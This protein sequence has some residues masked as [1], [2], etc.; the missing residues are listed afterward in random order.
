MED[1]NSPT[2][3]LSLQDCVDTDSHIYIYI[4]NQLLDKMSPSPD[5]ALRAV[6]FTAFV[7]AR[8]VAQTLKGA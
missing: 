3:V 6:V 2:Q 1:H 7:M 4:Y 5:L 8:A